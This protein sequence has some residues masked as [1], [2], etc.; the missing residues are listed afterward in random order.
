MDVV[1]Q[2]GNTTFIWDLEKADQNAR[3]TVCASR[4]R[5]PVFDDP[6]FVLVDASRQD[7]SRHGVIGFSAIGR[8][9]LVIHLDFDGD[10]IRL[11]SAR[12]A[13]TSEEE[14]YAQ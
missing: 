14:L 6:L 8:L 3:S 11:I 9:L 4:K 7:E 12:H 10:A 5:L 13:T 1:Y 2:H